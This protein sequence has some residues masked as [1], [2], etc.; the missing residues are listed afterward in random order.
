M[1]RVATLCIRARRLAACLSLAGAA[2]LLS[3]HA[4][5]LAQAPAFSIT[6]PSAAAVLQPGQPVT[7]QWTGGAPEW[8][9]DIQ[10]IDVSLG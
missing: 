9:V 10:L 6:A 4:A 8:S 3:M 5:A 7:I 2:A 1:K